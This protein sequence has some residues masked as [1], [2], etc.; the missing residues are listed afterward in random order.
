MLEKY[1]RVL[2]TGG[3]GFIGSH[4][5]EEL[6]GNGI[7]VVSIDNYLA[8]KSEH[9]KLFISNPDFTFVNADITNFN[10]IKP[11]FKDV[12]IV[13]HNAASKKTVCLIDPMRDLEINAK[14]TY[15][16][17]TAARACGVKKFIHASTGSVYG[18]PLYFPTDELHPT[19]P[20]SFYGVSKLAG[21]KYV[22][23]AKDIGDI[24]VTILRYHH[25]FGPRQDHS[26]FGG[27]VSI[28]IH[29]ALK[30]Q[31]IF[32]HGDGTQTRSFTFVKDV[33]NANFFVAECRDCKG[34]T[35]NVASGIKVS[36]AELVEGLRDMV[37]KHVKVIYDDWTP[38]DIRMFDVDNT[39]LTHLG[40]KYKT[41]F[42]AG[43]MKTLESFR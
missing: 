34:E 43:L 23:L 17:L 1:D 15:N 21:E 8:G 12:D 19:N 2:V 40:F 29:K 26:E 27:V 33:V 3:A 36:I 37:D 32:I 20:N 10:D 11:W 6:L 7:E 18:E 38:G 42:E 22:L 35:Y 16:V 39:K 24:D 30:G 4:I 9:T 14:G 13:F 5:I 31:P 41:S 25:V 28:F